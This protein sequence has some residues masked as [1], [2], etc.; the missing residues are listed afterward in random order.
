[1][2]KYLTTKESPT[3]PRLINIASGICGGISF[4]YGNKT[5]I[6]GQDDTFFLKVG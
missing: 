6:S 3:D 5:V 4:V 1:M 2:V